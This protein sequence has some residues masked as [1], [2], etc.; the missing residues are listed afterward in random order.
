MM[1]EK[2]TGDQMMQETSTPDAM[3]SQATPTPDA[4]MQET[5]TG[6]AMSG[7]S[8]A[9]TPAWLSSQLTSVRDSKNFALSDYKGKVVLVE[10][11]AVWCT[12]CKAQQ[13]QIKLLQ[14]KLG[15]PD[16]LVVVSLDIDPNED[17]DLLKNYVDENHL[18][19]T[20]AVA[21]KETSREIS[22]LFGDQ[23][24]NPPSAP[25]L[26]IDA[27]E[28]VYTLPFGLKSADDMQKPVE[29]YLSH[30]M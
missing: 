17:A 18:G 7:D 6:A 4:M 1:H 19:W 20:F 28:H 3:M 26:I 15:M 16:N 22:Q 2:P 12:T 14:E 24:L 8:M 23:F 29:Q 11:M 10:M 13:A 9:E 21:P 5:P 25:I 30:I 27:H